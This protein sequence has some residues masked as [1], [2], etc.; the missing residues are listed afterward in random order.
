MLP[1]SVGQGVSPSRPQAIRRW[2]AIMMVV[3]GIVAFG[4]TLTTA[5][6]ARAASCGSTFEASLDFRETFGLSTDPELIHRLLADPAADCT[7]TV[8]LTS[9]E[10]AEIDRRN[11]IE[12]Y[13]GGLSGF[14]D[15]HG[16]AF[17]GLYIDQQAGGIVVLLTTPS[18]TQAQIDEALALIAPG[19]P[20]WLQVTTREVKYSQRRLSTTQDEISALSAAEDPRVEGIVG[21]GRGTSENRVEVDI[22]VSSF[23]AVRSFLLERYPEDL[24]LFVERTSG[25]SGACRGCGEEPPE[26]GVATTPDTSSGAL[27][28]LAAAFCT[29]FATT[30]LLHPRRRRA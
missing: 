16:D 23:A 5:T 19:A 4:A 17:G 20:D 29:V 9:E 30:L 25:D 1:S 3:A 15:Q 2:A 22:L 13:I 24:L 28:L 14:V 18:T 6:L 7:W 10:A 27:A 12:L 11:M 8:P 21:L 26:T